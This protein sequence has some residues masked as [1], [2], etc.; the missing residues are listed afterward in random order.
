MYK[1]TLPFPVLP[2][3]DAN[4]VAR[5]L[6]ADPAGYG[7]S[8]RNL[9]IQMERAYEMVTPM[10]TFLV[11]YFESDRPFEEC[12]AAIARSDHPVD[13]AFVA[14]VKEVHG[15]DITQPPAGPPSELL[16]EY[17]DD[18]VTSRKR[19][20]AFCAPL[21]PGT[22]EIGRAFSKEAY[23]TRRDELTAS[24]RALGITRESVTLNAAP[25]RSQIGGIYI[26]GDH[27][28]AA[29]SAFAESKS[30]FDVWFKDECKR[31]FIPDID[32]NVPLPPITEV[33]DSQEFLVAR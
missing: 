14:A 10:G 25:D 17:A 21:M 5:V 19:G 2:G 29:N 30:E 28:V 26:E 11:V 32:F 6:K 1:A 24:R 18:T 23:T 31:L 12:A 4:Q 27:P 9:G 33:F 22:D 16:A 20:L 7:E 15:V 13:L 8:R 3:K